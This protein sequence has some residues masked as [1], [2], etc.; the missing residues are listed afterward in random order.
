MEYV[1]GADLG[2]GSVVERDVGEHAV[3]DFYAAVAVE[4]KAV[5]VVERHARQEREPTRLVGVEDVGMERRC[6]SEHAVVQIEQSSGAVGGDV[7]FD[8]ECSPKAVDEGE[9]EVGKAVGGE[10]VERGDGAG[11]VVEES[12]VGLAFA[13]Y[14]RQQLG[15]KCRYGGFHRVCTQPLERQQRSRLRHAANLLIGHNRG[16]ALNDAQRLKDAAAA[17]GL[18]SRADDNCERHASPPAAVGCQYGAVV[19]IGNA[20]Q[21]YDLNRLF[22]YC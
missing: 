14:G 15:Y 9:V 8:A 3:D 19:A 12:L 2:E 16:D 18:A 20:P 10:D 5:H 4:A 17:G 6:E 7:G 1:E 11:Y 21:R 22:H 13:E